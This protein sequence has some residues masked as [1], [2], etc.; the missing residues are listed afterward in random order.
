MAEQTDDFMSSIRALINAQML[1][2]NTSINGVIVDYAGGFATVKPTASKSFE[3]GDKLDY[4]NIYK[5][6]VRWPSFNGGKCG[7]KGPVKAGDPVLIV[8]SQ[9]AA[10]G[11]DD[12]RRFDL[13][14]AYAVIVDNSQSALGSNNDDMVMWFGDAYI[15]LTAAGALEINAPAGTKTIAPMN[16]YTGAVT[17]QG[18][19]TFLAG[20]IGSTASGVATTINGAINFIGSLTSNGKNISNTHIHTNSGGTGNGGP[21]A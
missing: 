1:Q 14:D 7:I 12:D 5:V 15:K 20:M 21:V 10:D 2:I 9:Q 11:S 19:F 18:V 6:P 8:F 3:D 13:T 17:V 16:I 4:P